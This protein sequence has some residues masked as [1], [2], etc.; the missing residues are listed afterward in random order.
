M[1]LL[2]SVFFSIK[3]FLLAFPGNTFP[4]SFLVTGETQ[5]HASRQQLKMTSQ[6]E[7]GFFEWRRYQLS[8]RL[9]LALE[10]SAVRLKK[11]SFPEFISLL[12]I[13]HVGAAK[14]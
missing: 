7:F 14:V 5:N 13:E 4:Q 6:L 10:Y 8:K 12:K 1:F 9:S 11:I 2:F 3:F